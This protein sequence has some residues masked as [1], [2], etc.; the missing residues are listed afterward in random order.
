MA[1]GLGLKSPGKAS[2]MATKPVHDTSVKTAARNFEVSGGRNK[3]RLSVTDKVR[4]G[5][6]RSAR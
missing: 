2:F 6:G 1:K 5:L 3:L 4:R